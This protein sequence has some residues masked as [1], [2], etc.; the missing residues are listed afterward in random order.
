MQ[1]ASANKAKH[2][3][4]EITKQVVIRLTRDANKE[5]QDG[6]AA[7]TLGGV[8]VTPSEMGSADGLLPALVWHADR[9][10]AYAMGR[11][12]GVEPDFYQDADA[13]LGK[14]VSM[15][16]ATCAQAEV[17]LF[18]LES[19][20]QLRET[21]AKDPANGV[22][23]RLDELVAEFKAAFKPVEARPGRHSPSM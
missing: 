19:F 9:V 23:A 7:F 22:S 5:S 6:L 16:R 12:Y 20:N 18:V 21:L 11:T 15:D 13:L 8:A 4:T 2:S 17:L 3:L 14:V 10:T 1:T